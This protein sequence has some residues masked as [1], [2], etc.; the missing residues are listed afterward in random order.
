MFFRNLDV[1]SKT[2]S[3][4]L[5]LIL[6]LIAGCNNQDGLSNHGNETDGY[7][8][9]SN[10]TTAEKKWDFSFVGA[11]DVSFKVGM[12]LE[13]VQA[14]CSRVGLPLENM[15]TDKEFRDVISFMAPAALDMLFIF[16]IKRGAFVGDQT[17][18]ELLT[19]RNLNG[20]EYPTNE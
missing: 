15:G 1:T 6:M 10:R 2:K 9:E 17:K 8:S 11:G 12:S 3:F 14:Q 16:Q 4:Y 5:V 18:I 7:S 19:I 13:D 20:Q